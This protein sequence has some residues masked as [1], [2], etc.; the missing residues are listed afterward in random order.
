MDKQKKNKLHDLIGIAC[1]VFLLVVLVWSIISAN[2]TK[3]VGDTN[4]SKD[5]VTLTGSAEGRNGPIE[6]EI[7]ADAEKIYQIRVVSHEET[8]GI[9]SVAVD[10]LPVS[11]YENQ[12]LSVDS[13]AGATITSDAIKAAV[14]N[15]LESG[16]FDPAVF[17]RAVEASAPVEKTDVE[18]TCDVVVVGAGGA[19]LTASVL[20]T[21]QGQDVILL[22]KMSFVGGNS[23]RAE[24]G[25]NAADTKVEA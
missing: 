3:T 4:V 11:I 6:V 9:G 20:A 15:A 1:G 24:G 17:Q 14:I 23:L 25:M 5:A 8:E 19:G 22:E 2:T 12:S 7:V 18:L 10:E 13:I 21:Q 16:G